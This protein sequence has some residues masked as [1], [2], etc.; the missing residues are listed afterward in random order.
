MEAEEPTSTDESPSG[1][2]PVAEELAPSSESSLTETITSAEPH[3]SVEEYVPST[4]PE[5]LEED[6]G[7][8]GEGDEAPADEDTK[9]LIF[10]S[11]LQKL[12][13]FCP[14]CG[15]PVVKQRK[16]YS[17]T[18]ATFK[19]ECHNGCTVNWS[20]QPKVN[21]QPLGNILIAA[22]IRFTGLTFRRVAD[23]A[24][25]VKLQFISQATFTSIQQRYLWPVVN[26]AWRNEQAQAIREAKA[27]RGAGALILGG[28]ARC[29]SPGHNAR[30]GSYTLMDIRPKTPNLIMS[31]ELVHS[32]EV[33]FPSS[34]MLI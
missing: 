32:S 7:E 33:S 28:D 11:S 10:E 30:Y 2:S 16:L 15:S 21:K 5:S 29:D 24:A 4:E 34:E 26:E 9:L 6:E 19:L 23:W 14:D 12:L 22:A 13:K 8:E 17:G 27:E 31:M 20:S 18:L 3:E 1:S 25:A